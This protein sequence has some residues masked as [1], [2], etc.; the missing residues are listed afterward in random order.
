MV[1]K[2]RVT[3]SNFGILLS[4]F[5]LFIM[6]QSKNV[7][8]LQTY[9]NISCVILSISLKGLYSLQALLEY[10][11]LIIIMSS[12]RYNILQGDRAAK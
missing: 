12:I 11:L 3:F 4:T 8:H 9:C 6:L 10:A 2:F 7:I 5:R 1:F